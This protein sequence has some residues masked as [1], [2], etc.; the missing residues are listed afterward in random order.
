[1]FL[2]SHKDREADFHGFISAS[3]SPYMNLAT[4]SVI[5]G[6]IVGFF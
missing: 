1:M 5:F 2:T 3:Q 4:R 6:D